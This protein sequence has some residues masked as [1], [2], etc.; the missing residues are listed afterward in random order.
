MT[1]ALVTWIA[2][3]AGTVAGMWLSAW[4][5]NDTEGNDE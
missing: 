4:F 3:N 5:R 2:F 1:C